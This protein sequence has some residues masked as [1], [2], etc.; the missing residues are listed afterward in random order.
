MPEIGVFTLALVLLPTERVPLHIFEPRY[1]ELIGECISTGAP[2]GLLLEDDS[3]RRDVGTLATVSEVVHVFDDGRM[4]IVVEGGERFRIVTWTDGRRFP[5]A[6]VEAFADEE[7]ALD[8]GASQLRAEQALELFRR[9]AAVAD[10][11]A[12][13]PD[14][15]SGFLSFE[16]ASHIDFGHRPEQELLEIRSESE[17]LERLTEL[18]ERALD[19][20]TRERQIRARASTNGRV[21][22]G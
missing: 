17:R 21:S 7:G 3:G 13:D 12:A 20:M 16:I 5:T 14:G 1:K 6:E 18:L 19:V 10:A 15:V 2:F 11:E 9:L 4:N 22:H 8:A